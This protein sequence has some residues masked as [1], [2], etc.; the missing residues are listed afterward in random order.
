MISPTQTA[1]GID[2]CTGGKD[3]RKNHIDGDIEMMTAPA[4]KTSVLE[5]NH[6]FVSVSRLEFLRALDNQSSGTVGK[7]EN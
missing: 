6:R 3:S 7:L 2:L 1:S 5:R 4:K